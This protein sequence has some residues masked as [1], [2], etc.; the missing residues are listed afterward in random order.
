MAVLDSKQQEFFSAMEGT[1]NTPGWAL[2]TQGWREEQEA[3]PQMTF[4]NAKSMEDVDQAR[5]RFGLL[6]ELVNLPA[7]ISH[8]R[9]EIENMDEEPSDG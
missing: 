2:L 7:A 5:V 9:S 8:Q 1:F 3:L 4:F 6:N